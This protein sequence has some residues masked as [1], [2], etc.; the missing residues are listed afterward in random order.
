LWI[1]DDGNYP[2]VNQDGVTTTS[3]SLTAVPEPTTILS[4]VL[5]L[6]PFGASTLRILRRKQVA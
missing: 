3:L 6:L 2:I 5:M 1:G 4:G